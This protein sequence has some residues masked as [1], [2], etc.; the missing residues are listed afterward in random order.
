MFETFSEPLPNIEKALERI[1][2]QDIELKKD[3]PS[4]D[5]LIRSYLQ[6]VPYENFEVSYFHR[7]PSLKIKDLYEKIVVN[8]R[9]GFCFEMNGFFW[10]L[11]RDL[12]FDVYSVSVYVLEFKDELTDL[13]HRANIVTI[14]DRK[15]LVDVG[16]GGPNQTRCAIPLDGKI[17]GGFFVKYNESKREYTLYR[18]IS[19]DEHLPKDKQAYIKKKIHDGNSYNCISVL[20]FRDFIAYPQEF[21]L[22]NLA[23]P[24]VTYNPMATNLICNIEKIDGSYYSLNN[25][26]FKIKNESG[27]QVR[28]IADDAEFKSILKEYF[29]FEL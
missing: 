12:G 14:D 16:F 23:T 11:L 3:L 28:T 27:K 6:N 29:G 5:L 7:A 22:I 19:E 10:A 17:R 13:E 1:G 24:H 2:L 4:L 9:G 25:N 8:K 21:N 15:Y 20:M 26:T 18:I